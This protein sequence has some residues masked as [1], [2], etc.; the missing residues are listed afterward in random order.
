M[1]GGRR[2]SDAPRVLRFTVSSIRMFVLAVH[3]S[4]IGLGFPRAIE[5]HLERLADSGVRLPGSR[6]AEQPALATG[7]PALRVDVLVAVRRRAGPATS[8]SRQE[9]TS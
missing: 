1:A 5:E 6:L 3:H 2:A 9:Q 8:A 7:R 4:T